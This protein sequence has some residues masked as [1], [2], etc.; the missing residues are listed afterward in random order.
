MQVMI[1]HDTPLPACHAG[2]TARHMH[3][4]RRME[5][6]GGHSIECKCSHTGRHSDFDGAMRE[7][8]QMQGIAKP[9]T[10][11]RPRAAKATPGENVPATV[12]VITC[13]DS[14]QRE[15][16]RR[17]L[18]GDFELADAMELLSKGRMRAGHHYGGAWHEYDLQFGIWI[19]GRLQ[20][21]A[22][23]PA[24]GCQIVDCSIDCDCSS[25]DDPETKLVIGLNET[26][27]FTHFDGVEIPEHYTSG[28]TPIWA[29][30]V[31][32]AY[33]AQAAKPE[34]ATFFPS[35]AA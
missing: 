29:Q 24:V 5:A 4:K 34:Q 22:Y 26:V 28:R 25:E 15:A 13:L 18:A 8:Q 11:S 12:G 14:M 3:D 1:S 20:A 10:K 27:L 19:G 16:M 17:A 32:D 7:W 23:G 31:I 2:H 9:A 30:G 33:R 35:E 21:C 6:D